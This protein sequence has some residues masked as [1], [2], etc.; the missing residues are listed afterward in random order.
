MRIS[1]KQNLS[2]KSPKGRLFQEKSNN[3][4]HSTNKPKLICTIR[5]VKTTKI[6]MAICKALSEPVHLSLTS[7]KEVLRFERELLSAL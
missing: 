4:C 6:S 7:N 3:I 5:V 1:I 2:T